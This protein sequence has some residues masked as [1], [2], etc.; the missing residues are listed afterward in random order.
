MLSSLMADALNKREESRAGGRKDENVKVR[1]GSNANGQDQDWVHEPDSKC[2]VFR[3][4]SQRSQ[5][6][7]VWIVNMLY[8]GRQEL[9]LENW[10]W[11][12]GVL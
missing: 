4:Q 5:T 6:E 8:I 1:F 3:R 7:T 12:A 11:Q 9:K 2:H 10:I